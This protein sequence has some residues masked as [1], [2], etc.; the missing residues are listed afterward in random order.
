MLSSCGILNSNLTR[1]SLYVCNPAR[2]ANLMCA[3][4]WCTRH[5]QRGRAAEEA[6][7]VFYYLTYEGAVSLADIPDPQQRKVR[8]MRQQ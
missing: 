1:D 2:P 5:K 7:N 8:L 6:A 4:L 3:G